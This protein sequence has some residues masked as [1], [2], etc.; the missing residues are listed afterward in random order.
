MESAFLR[1]SNIWAIVIEANLLTSGDSRILPFGEVN[2]VKC[3]HL[4]NQ[5]C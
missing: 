4:G 1:E 5:I 3:L 2:D